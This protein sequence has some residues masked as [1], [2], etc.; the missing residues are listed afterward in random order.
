MATLVETFP[1]GMLQCNCTIVACEATRE[2]IVIDPGDEAPAI[3]ERL[4]QNDLTPRYLIHT[5]AHIDHVMATT[6]VKRE[7]GAKALLH[8]DDLPLYQHLEMQ[9]QLLGIRQLGPSDPMDGELRHEQR[10]TFGEGHS[11]D[12]LHTPGHTPGSC[13][14]QL[15]VDD[16]D[17]LFSGDTLFFRGVGRT[18]LWGGSYP[19][20]M[21]SIQERLVPLDGD[22]RVIAGH[23]PGTTIGDERLKNPFLQN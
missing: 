1:V 9:A 14:F 20:L 13:C 19:Q 4:R 17:L 22:T 5:H 3:L 23:G 8:K 6:P 10:L 12:V 2:A 16:Q 11:V 7:T 18:D 21:R 15:R